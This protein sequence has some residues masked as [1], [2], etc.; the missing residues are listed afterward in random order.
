[1]NYNL[2]IELIR[3]W[4]FDSK[5][6]NSEI[7]ELYLLVNLELDLHFP[8]TDLFALLINYGKFV[9]RKIIENH[10]NNLIRHFIILIDFPGSQ[11]ITKIF[12]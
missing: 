5:A 2:F 7:I 11:K 9:K 1:M 10:K 8:S 6:F 12:S 3:S 4:N